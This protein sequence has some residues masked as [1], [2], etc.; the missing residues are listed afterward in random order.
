MSSLRLKRKALR[1]KVKANT[2]KSS[3]KALMSKPVTKRV[4]IEELKEG[5]KKKAVVKEVA[6][7]EEAPV[8]EKKAPVAKAKKTDAEPKAA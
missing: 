1:N 7:K 5:F 8:A 2:R 4:S 3:I 6:K